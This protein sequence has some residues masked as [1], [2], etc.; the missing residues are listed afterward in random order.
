MIGRLGLDR[1]IRSLARRDLSSAA[2][3][4]EAVARLVAVVQA[5]GYCF[6]EADP[7]TMTMTM[8]ATVNLDRSM[9]SVMYRNE[10]GQAD[11]LKHRDLV[12]GPVPAGSLHRATGGRPERSQRFVSLLR[13]LGLGDELR[14]AAVVDGKV[15]GFVHMF[16]S[17]DRAPF[18]PDD[19]DLVAALSPLLG[20]GVRAGVLGLS[21]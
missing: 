21:E 9:S 10:Y 16:R 3:R 8:H 2:F 15:W 1:D 18:G 5:D 14:A 6:A 4:R 17:V 20:A 19:V 11:F 13:P 12:R 7:D